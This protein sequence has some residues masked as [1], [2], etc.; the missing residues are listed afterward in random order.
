MSVLTLALG[1]GAAS[2]IVTV[3]DTILVQPLPYPDA[4]RLV[5]I[6]EHAPPTIPGRPPF[7]RGLSYQEFR[8]WRQ[9]ARTL[10]D[11]TAIMAMGQRTVRTP[12]GVAGLWGVMVAPNAFAIF[13]TRAA[14]GRTLTP[15]DEANPDV[16][17]L[18]HNVWQRHFNGDPA[19]VGSTIEL[20]AGALAPSTVPR[21]LTVV[22]VLPSGFTLPANLVDFVTPT[23]AA[24]NQRAVR[25][26]TIGKLAAGVSLDAAIAE[27]NAMGSAMRPAW[28]ANVPLLDGPRFDVVPVKEGTVGSLRPALRVLF[29]AV[30]VLLLI[31]CAN[32]ANLL[33]GRG[34]ARRREMAVRLAIG[35]SRGRIFRQVLTECLLLS[36]LAGCLAVV[37]ASAG[38]MLVKTLAEVEVPGIFRLMFGST[39]LPRAHEIQVN[40]RVLGVT[41]GIAS[42]DNDRIRHAACAP[43]RADAPAPGCRRAR[44]NERPF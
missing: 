44:R 12:H 10:S 2:A 42:P 18:S 5:R 23:F 24:L 8:D 28:P 30:V 25:V 33:L 32:V 37:V 4:D 9:H 38:V 1:I 27:A 34:N 15:E 26:S 14:L 35:A 3:V 36:A 39:V 21:L 43:T 40:A 16:V 41:F 19:L 20:R 13:P 31:V 29:A 7:D 22:G 6:F 11:A 17:V